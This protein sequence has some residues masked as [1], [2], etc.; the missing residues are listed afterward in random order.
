M[1]YQVAGGKI[2]SG[3]TQVVWELEEVKERAGGHFFS[4]WFA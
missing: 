3:L 4:Q 2:F 1:R